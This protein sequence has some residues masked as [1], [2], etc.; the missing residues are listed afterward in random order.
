M[1]CKSKQQVLCLRRNNSMHQHMLGANQLESSLT[2]KMLG[3]LRDGKLTMKQQWTLVAKAANSILG[4]IQEEHYQ[5]AEGGG[6][7]SLLSTQHSPNTSGVLGPPVQDR[8]EH[9]RGSLG[10]VTKLVKSWRTWY[11]QTRCEE[12]NHSSWRREGLRGNL[13]LS[14]TT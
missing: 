8:R 5:Q 9:T 11:L 1:F 14:S 7:P 2:G 4:C 3:V 6:F 10:Q 12:Q 13:L